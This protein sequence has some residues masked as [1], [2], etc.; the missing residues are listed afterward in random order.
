MVKVPPRRSSGETRPARVFSI[1]AADSRAIW[2]RDF[3]CTSRSTGTSRPR[4][5]STAIPMLAVAACT[6][7]S[8]SKRALTAGCSSRACAE[9]F[10]RRSLYDGTGCAA[11]CRARL[12]GAPLCGAT[13]SLSC[14]RRRTNPVASASVVSVTAATVWLLAAMRS[15]VMR[16]TVEMGWIAG[17]GRGSAGGTGGTRAA[18]AFSASMRAASCSM[19]ARSMR[20]PG[21]R[22][23]RASIS[24]PCSAARRRARG[25]IRSAAAGSAWAGVGAA[26]CAAA[27]R[28]SRSTMR[29]VRPLPV[30]P[31]QSTPS[32]PATRRARGLIVGA[33]GAP[34]AGTLA[35]AGGAA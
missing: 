26:G 16:R 22:A 3:V 11:L 24:T 33:P 23:A 4:S 29:P 12:C 8:P 30:R 13:S 27:A 14:F 21:I 34:R 7:P 1:S 17:A 35:T 6:M 9:S 15:A 25:L 19:S 2:R 31:S 10:A 28:T 18:A 5:V 20:L 32:S